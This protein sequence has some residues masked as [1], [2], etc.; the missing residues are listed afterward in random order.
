MEIKSGSFISRQTRHVYDVQ[1]DSA[2]LPAVVEKKDS[3]PRFS[4]ARLNP[5]VVDAPNATLE[6]DKQAKLIRSIA[7]SPYLEAEYDVMV[8]PKSVQDYITIAGITNAVPKKN[9]F[10]ALA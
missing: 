2:R 5:A 10:D 3:Q 7:S 8:L 9:K 6:Q 4:L 1:S